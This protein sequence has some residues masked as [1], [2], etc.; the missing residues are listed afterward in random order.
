MHFSLRGSPWQ[1]IPVFAEFH[2]LPHSA[3]GNDLLL[4]GSYL[5]GVSFNWAPHS[6]LELSKVLIATPEIIRPELAIP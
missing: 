6:F 5:R 1:A 3:M 4:A 2:L